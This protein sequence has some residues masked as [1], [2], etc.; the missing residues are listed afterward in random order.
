M[1]PGLVQR[2]LRAVALAIAGA[3]WL[4]PASSADGRPRVAVIAGD[5]DDAAL[6]QSVRASLAQ[7]FDVTPLHEPAASAWVVVSSRPGDDEPAWP[8]AMPVSA[9]VATTRAVTIDDMSAPDVVHVSARAAIE[10]TVHRNRHA[11][12]ST[13][14]TLRAGTLELGR[15]TIR[16][17]SPDAR[18][19]VRFDLLLPAAGANHLTMEAGSARGDLVVDVRDERLPVLVFEPR[20][21]WATTFVR[22]ALEADARFDVDAVTRVSTGITAGRAPPDFAGAGLHRY[23]VLIVGGADALSAAEVDRLRRFAR[24]GGGRV[25]VALDGLPSGPVLGLLPASSFVERSLPKAAT[26]MVGGEPVHAREW[27]IGRE[28]RR[29]ATSSPVLSD[30][31]PLGPGLIAR[32]EGRGEVTLVGAL[33]AWRSRGQD[34]R[35]FTRAWTGL[36]AH[37]GAGVPRMSLRLEPRVVSPDDPVAVRVDLGPSEAA[38]E[39][40]LRATLTSDSAIATPVRLWPD[41]G[42]RHFAGRLHAPASQGLYRLSVHA[43]TGNITDSA[44]VPLVVS[45]GARPAVP[46][47]RFQI[48]VESRGGVIVDPTRLDRLTAHLDRT[49][50]NRVARSAWHPMRSPWWLAVFTACLGGE[51]WLRRRAG[52]R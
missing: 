36:V 38:T 37:L 42:G 10:A 43:M 15:Q 14:V 21:S 29:G 20:P 22:R 40:R 2:G 18:S 3:A 16:W 1:S 12:S 23:R 27:A 51:W 5:T 50:S 7:R 45:A 11:E 31:S 32:A 47:E 48:A 17:T 33:D 24:E 26:V 28:I 39:L 41:A 8:P 35:G 13:V 44:H 25:V 9:V 4:D 46:S 19:R 34:A 52:R 30:G 6:L 49:L